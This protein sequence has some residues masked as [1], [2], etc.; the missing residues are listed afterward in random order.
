MILALAHLQFGQTD[1]A[2]QLIQRGRQIY[3]K[4]D[5]SL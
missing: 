4:L 1:K 3:Q 5:A 2:Y